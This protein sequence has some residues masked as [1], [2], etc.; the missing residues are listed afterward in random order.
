MRDFFWIVLAYLIAI[1]TACL[2]FINLEGESALLRFF[3]ADLVATVVVFLFSLAFRNSSFYDP[4]WSIAPIVLVAGFIFYSNGAAVLRQLVVALLVIT[5]GVRLT[6]NWAYG[7]HGLTHEDWRYTNLQRQTGVFWWP[8]SFLGI[9]LLPTIIV[10]LGCLSLYQALAAGT[11]PVNA[12]DGLALLITASAIWLETRADLDLHHFRS[13]RQSNTEILTGGVWGWCRHPNYLG[14]IGFWIGI[15]V[16]GYAAQGSTANDIAA[17]PVAMVLLFLFV[18]IPMIERKL[19]EDK[20]DYAEYKQ[21][22]FAL[23][24]LSGWNKH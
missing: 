18:S 24:P 4:Y 9:H 14:E 13:T 5:W 2:L 1:A 19:L 12:W 16:F 7:W 6:W 11:V 10:F 15:F 21:S 3:I 22:S 8:V 20:P 17:G 23:I